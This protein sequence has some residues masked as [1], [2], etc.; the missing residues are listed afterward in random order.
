MTTDKHTRAVV[1][2]RLDVADD[3]WTV[4]IRPEEPV[5][6]KP[7]QYATLGVEAE[8]RMIERAYS[9]ASSPLED[10]LEFFIELVP[11]GKLTPRLHALKEG[12]S[13][14]IR[15]LT[16]G[17]FVFDAR[18]DKINHLMISTVTG[19][20]PFV[21]MARTQVRSIADGAAADRRF[22]LMQGASRSWE[23]AYSD[24]LSRLDAEND[25]LT[26]VPTVSRPHE[27]ADWKGLTGRVH[28]L[29]LGQLE[30]FCCGPKETVAYLCG[31]PG[32]IEAGRKMLIEAGFANEDVHEEK[33]WIP[34]KGADEGDTADA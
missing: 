20:A 4:R 22:Y 17:H 31:H 34:K 32:M 26:Y 6:F 19:I 16:R 2:R 1:T 33:Y 30:R 10:E 13:L 21:S 11:H 15:K 25:W 18:E 12:D 5:S 3:L 24:E 9:I 28:D 27:D 8:P 7:G 29:V 14:W 23:L